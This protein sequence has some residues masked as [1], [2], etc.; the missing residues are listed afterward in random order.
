MGLDTVELL[1]AVEDSFDVRIRHEEAA[2]LESLSALVDHLARRL[3]CAQEAT[4]LTQTAFYRLRRALMES[5]GV[6]RSAL[7]PTSRLGLYLPQSRRRTLWASLAES[8]GLDVPDL[9][10]TR[11]ACTVGVSLTLAL[12]LAGARLGG[13]ALALA[14]MTA[15]VSSFVLMTREWRTRLPFATV[16]ELAS[17][18]AIYGAA[19]LRRREQG[20]TRQQIETVVMGLTKAVTGVEEVPPDAT[21]RELGLD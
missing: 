14:V 17:W 8:T 4:C 7:R 13:L 6:E 10:Y 19:S 12:T 9:R 20:W 16:G 21:F 3:P 2:E 5:T 11:A 18:A 15:S 1:L